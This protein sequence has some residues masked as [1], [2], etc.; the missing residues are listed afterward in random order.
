M[1]KKPSFTERRKLIEQVTNDLVAIASQLSAAAVVL[2]DET[3][4]MAAAEKRFAS[5]RTAPRAARER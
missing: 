1:D 3:E 2:T 4:R 5:A